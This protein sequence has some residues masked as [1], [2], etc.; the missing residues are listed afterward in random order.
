MPLPDTCSRDASRHGA[1][2]K[3]EEPIWKLCRVTRAGRSIGQIAH[4]ST[5]TLHDVVAADEV[6]VALPASQT[7]ARA[8]LQPLQSHLDACIAAVER[9]DAAALEA[10][11]I[12]ARVAFSQ[13]MLIEQLIVPLMAVIGN[14]WCH[15]S[16]RIMHEPLASAVV[17]TFVGNLNSAA[18]LSASAL[19]LIV[20]T[21]VG[22]WHEIGA[23][24]VASTATTE[25]WRVAYLGANLPAEE[26]VAA[27]QQHLA[28][29]VALSIIHPSD[30]AHLQYELLKLRRY[31]PQNVEIIVGGRASAD[32]SDVLAE[33]GVMR[34]DSMLQLCAQL[35]TLRSRLLSP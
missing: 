6:P 1:V 32:Y 29:A 2:R 19:T 31:L 21:P 7:R 28:K 13:P 23:L 5:T 20:T 24:I 9:L 33:I 18:E 15:G 4:L 22:Q 8:E 27:A 12:R 35:E 16:L 26:T 17:R 11:L 30:D 14:L 34:L 3:R 10:I 25:G